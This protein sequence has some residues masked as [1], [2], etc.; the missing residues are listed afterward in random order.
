MLHFGQCGR[1]PARSRCGPGAGCGLAGRKCPDRGIGA[2]FAALIGVREPADSGILATSTSQGTAGMADDVLEDAG[3]MPEG[4]KVKRTPPTIDLEATKVS[5][6]ASAEAKP[7]DAA[8]RPDAGANVEPPKSESPN[9]EPPK[10]EASASR[11]IS[12][13]LTAP[14]SGVIG[15]AIVI[16]VGWAIGWPS[17]QTPPAEP[18]VSAAAVDELGKRVAS[19]ESK[20]AKAPAPVADPAMT[21]RLDALE[22]SQ[23]TLRTDLASLRAQSD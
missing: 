13:W 12:P 21:T 2:C 17:M 19:L 14:V 20:T 5:E 7:D 8:A 6:A 9:P 22:K 4:G 1:N 16:A 10:A 18:Q 15:A 3:P 23:A 11:P